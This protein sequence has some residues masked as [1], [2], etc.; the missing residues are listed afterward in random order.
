[1]VKHPTREDTSLI[2]AY[3]PA[4]R[5]CAAW[6]S[7]RPVYASLPRRIRHWVVAESRRKPSTVMVPVPGG[8]VLSARVEPWTPETGLKRFKDVL[9]VDAAVE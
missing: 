1:M 7:T 6:F 4:A 5:C 3:V 9:T 8:G 2:R